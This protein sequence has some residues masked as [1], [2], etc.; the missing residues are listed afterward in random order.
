LLEGV[1]FLHSNHI[2]H[3]DLKP[4]NLLLGDQH[5]LKIIDFER[6]KKGNTG[7]IPGR[8]TKNYRAPEVKNK[9]CDD[10]KS[11]DVYSMGII[12]FVMTCRFH[13]YIE[14]KEIKGFDLWELMLEN[15]VSYWEALKDCKGEVDHLSD[16]FKRLF[17]GMVRRNA[18]ERHTLEEIKASNWYNGP[19]Y[20]PKELRNVMSKIVKDKI[21]QK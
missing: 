11:A 10:P 17:T 15:R 9:E 1:E 18:V 6:S 4:E 12:L 20:S 2:A 13:P 7:K 5:L 8:G 19:V 3:T 21:S 14:D 16:D